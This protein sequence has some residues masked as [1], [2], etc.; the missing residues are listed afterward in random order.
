MALQAGIVF[1]FGLASLK[2]RRYHGLVPWSF[3]FAAK[4][5]QYQTLRMPRACPVEFHVCGYLAT[6]VIPPRRKAV[7]SGFFTKHHQCSD[8]HEIPRD[9]PVASFGTLKQSPSQVYSSRCS[10]SESSK[11]GECR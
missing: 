4:Q 1:R 10:K 2:S 11:R 3:M 9:K 5:N 7:A 6:N 8:Q